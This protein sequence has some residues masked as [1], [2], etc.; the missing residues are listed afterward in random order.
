MD[1]E[2]IVGTLWVASQCLNNSQQPGPAN[3]KRE[4]VSSSGK[5]HTMGG[6]TRVSA[7]MTKAFSPD[8]TANK[9]PSVI[10]GL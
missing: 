3:T 1:R 10:S 8:T 2:S 6:V 4:T 7:N 9:R 5:K